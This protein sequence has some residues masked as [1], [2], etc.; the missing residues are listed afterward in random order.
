[1][2]YYLQRECNLGTT[3]SSNAI[4][5]FDTEIALSETPSLTP[6]EDF[7]YQEDGSIHIMRAGTYTVFWYTSCMTSQSTV[8]Q[9][10]T[11]KKLDYDAPSINW[12]PVVGTGSHIKVSQ[13]PGFAIVVI[14]EDEINEHGKATIAL[15]NTADTSK[16]FTFFTPKAGILVFGFDLDSVEAQMTNIADEITSIFDNLQRIEDFVNLSSV[17]EMWALL[18]ELSGLGV[19]VIH[20]GYTHNFWGIGT[21]NHQQTLNSGEVYYLVAS[22][23]YEPL[24]YY[25]GDSTIGTLWIE[26]PSPSTSVYSFPIRF[27]ATGIYFIPDT[28]YQNLPPGTAFK[29]T[30][31]LILVDSQTP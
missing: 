5:R 6:S 30:Q 18:P 26:T 17:T 21:L 20:S 25:Q 11:L 3:I 9:S 2:T 22:S 12:L 1:M 4:I 27:N 19:A 8:G 13:V 14:S 28:T 24:T 7:Q 23:Q 16:E 10:F 29:F 15:F 31:A